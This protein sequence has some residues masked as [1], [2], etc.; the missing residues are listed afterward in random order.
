MTLPLKTSCNEQSCYS[1]SVGKLGLEVLPNPPYSPDLA[2]VTIIFLDQWR[3]CYVAEICIWY[4]N[5]INCSSVTQTTV[6]IIF[7]IPGFPKLVD[8]WDKCSNEFGWYVEKW[9][10][11]VW[12]L[13]RFTFELVHFSRNSQCCLTLGELWRKSGGQ[14]TTLTDCISV[15]VTSQ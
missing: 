15:Q 13:N 3:K 9:N 1:F 12:R 4:S 14:N 5:A 8:R 7:I 6:T 10:I 2:P 11:N